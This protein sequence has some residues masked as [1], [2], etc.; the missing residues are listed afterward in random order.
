MY[1]NQCLAFSAGYGTE[2]C[3][4]APNPGGCPMIYEPILC[5]SKCPYDNYCISDLA[6]YSDSQCTGVDP[7]CDNYE[8]I[9]EC[10]SRSESGDR[11]DVYLR[12]PS[13]SLD[14]EVITYSAGICTNKDNTEIIYYNSCYDVSELDL[15]TFGTVSAGVLVTDVTLNKNGAEIDSWSTDSSQSWCLSDDI[16]DHSGLVVGGDNWGDH[17][18]DQIYFTPTGVRTGNFLP[19]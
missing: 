15:L 8:F 5:G 2:D 18:V 1:D 10:D 3:C 19:R 12:D 14:L 11:V 13:R 9:I 16:D 7:G 17:C 6:G 4:S